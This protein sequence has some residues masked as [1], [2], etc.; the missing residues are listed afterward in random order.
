MQ[1]YKG[2]VYKT[3]FVSYE[4]HF[5]DFILSLSR[6]FCSAAQCVVYNLFQRCKTRKHSRYVQ[7]VICGLKD[8]FKKSPLLIMSSDGL[9]FLQQYDWYNLIFA[10]ALD[11]LS[12]CLS[13][14]RVEFIR[15]VKQLRIAGKMK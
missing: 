4:G 3:R 1:L 14:V 5:K 15:M 9:L 11:P 12:Y 13:T 6:M 10:C 2:E 8:I 7:Y